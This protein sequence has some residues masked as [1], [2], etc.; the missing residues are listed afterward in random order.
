MQRIDAW[1]NERTVE[2]VDTH[3]PTWVWLVSR[4]GIVGEIGASDRREVT[5]MNGDN[6]VLVFLQCRADWL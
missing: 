5:V 2:E 1:A 6:R 4:L 3:C